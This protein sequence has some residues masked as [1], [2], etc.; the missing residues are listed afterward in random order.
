[1]TGASILRR[2]PLLLLSAALVALAVFAVH[3]SPRAQAQAANTVTL[4]ASPTTVDEGSPVTITATLSTALGDTDA[5]LIIPLLI[6]DETAEPSD[7]G[8]L[9]QLNILTGASIGVGT[10]STVR[11]A[12]GDHERFTVSLDTANLPSGVAAGAQSSVTITIR[13]DGLGAGE[14]AALQ[15]CWDDK[16]AGGFA[17]CTFADRASY[18]WRALVDDTAGHVKVRPTVQQAG[19]TVRVGPHAVVS[20]SQS[21]VITLDTAGEAARVNT[22][23]RLA[24]SDSAG[25]PR[26]YILSVQRRAQGP[27]QQPSASTQTQT[28]TVWSA[29]LTV[30]DEGGLFGCNFSRGCA[31]LLTDNDFSYGGVDYQ[32]IQMLSRGGLQFAV[33]KPVPHSLIRS[34]VL[35]VDGRTLRLSDAVLAHFLRTSNNQLSW[36]SLG[37][38]W[39]PGDTVSLSLAER[40]STPTVSLSASPTTVDEG[41]PVTITVNLSKALSSRVTIP[42]IITD[43]TAEP[44]DYSAPSSITISAGE[45]SGAAAIATRQDADTHDETF[46]VSLGELPSAVAAG[47]PSSVEITIIDDDLPFGVTTTG[48]ST[49]LQILPTDDSVTPVPPSQRTPEGASASEGFCYTTVGKGD[50]EYIRY[51]DGRLVETT[52]Q[53]TY[54]RSVFACN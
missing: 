27:A 13:D 54:I 33:D 42:L 44:S 6:T 35:I 8:T 7:H 49:G 29:T 36:S 23:I 15:V 19:A 1:M 52:K 16:A 34:L 31:D 12:D 9:A 46:T 51:P 39:S 20:G 11:D 24:F 45:T 37:L 48:S 10:I 5:R 25:V 30:R 53:S 41:S 28:R 14:V 17:D 21:G 26:E 47:S 43:G 50:T 38:S 18:G 40:S 22:N 4:S 3:D 2:S 32:F